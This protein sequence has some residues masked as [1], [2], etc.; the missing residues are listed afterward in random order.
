MSTNRDKA[1]AFSTQE[2]LSD[3]MGKLITRNRAVWILLWS[4]VYSTLALVG[5]G[6]SLWIDEYATIV[7]SSGSLEATAQDPGH[8]PG[9][10]LLLW[11]LVHLF[12]DAEWT[13][14]FPSLVFGVAVIWMTYLLADR[15]SA[16]H[17]VSIL[18]VP[19]LATNPYLVRFGNE[20]RAYTL[21]PFL[22]LLTTYLYF[23]ARDQDQMRPWLTTAASGVALAY[24]HYYGVAY[25]ALLFCYH[26]VN[27]AYARVARGRA[28]QLKGILG[29]YVLI[30]LAALPLV[31]IVVD[32]FGVLAAAHAGRLI[33][34]QQIL[35][36]TSAFF[37][38]A[39]TTGYELTLEAVAYV[40]AWSTPFLLLILAGFWRTLQARRTAPLPL[41]LTMIMAA[42]VA[43]NYALHLTGYWFFNIRY[44]LCLLPVLIILIAEGLAGLVDLVSSRFMI[45]SVAGSALGRLTHR[46]WTSRRVSWLAVFVLGVT[47]FGLVYAPR[48]LIEADSSYPYSIAG[49]AED[50]RGA[51]KYIASYSDTNMTVLVEPTFGAGVLDYYARTYQGRI[52]V[53]GVS[54]G[55]SL[56]SLLESL[57]LAEGS[58]WYVWSYAYT[59]DPEGQVIQWASSNGYLYSQTDHGRLV[60]CLFSVQSNPFH[61]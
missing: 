44:V 19:M 28:M 4:V 45:L 23:I 56:T 54:Y 25:L 13:V 46:T 3:E 24:V 55:A 49:G 20:A 15:V 47:L 32:Q 2:K 12:G 57:I 27:S 30:G 41:D 37:L 58:V 40:A 9:Y 14:R 11:P 18:T 1:E 34:P 7:D 33:K 26:I 51:I 43:A 61:S 42:F 53:T 35:F 8:P 22:I 16:D 21:L 10:F 48:I 31:P 60:V 39:S 50:N 38:P 59:L 17:R 6:R 5:F 36:L 29:A 52:N